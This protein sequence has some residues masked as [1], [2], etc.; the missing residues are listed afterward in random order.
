MSADPGKRALL[1]VYITFT[2]FLFNIF[3]SWFW[4]CVFSLKKVPH[5]L[6]SWQIVFEFGLSGGHNFSSS[7]DVFL[8]I[9]TMDKRFSD[10]NVFF[11]F[12]LILETNKIIK[13]KSMKISYANVF[14][15]SMIFPDSLRR[16]LML[17]LTSVCVRS[18]RL[19][20]REWKT[21]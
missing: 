19:I 21:T 2:S 17:E 15:F 3:Q 10:V 8:Q 5:L 11:F 1:Q 14:F 4:G 9:E 16:P 18:H 20:D 6:R 7:A 13:I 12:F